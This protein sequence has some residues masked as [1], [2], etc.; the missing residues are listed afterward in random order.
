MTTLLEVAREAGGRLLATA[1]LSSRQNH[2]FIHWISL[3]RDSHGELGMNYYIIRVVNRSQYS[4]TKKRG[5]ERLSV[6]RWQW[7]LG[8]GRR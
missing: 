3:K 8:T 5:D 4:P 2:S 7:L 1:R 6:L